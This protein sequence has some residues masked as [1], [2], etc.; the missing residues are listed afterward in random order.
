MGKTL[1][2]ET[3]LATGSA[4]TEKTIQQPGPEFTVNEFSFPPRENPTDTA[5]MTL[6]C[7]PGVHRAKGRVCFEASTSTVSLT[8]SQGVEGAAIFSNWGR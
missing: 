5:S 2:H 4:S 8:P 1:Q 6:L 3:P 7:H